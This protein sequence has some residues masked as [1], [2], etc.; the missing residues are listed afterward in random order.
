MN[1]FSNLLTKIEDK[2]AV[3]G[4]VGIGYVGKAEGE[5]IA[6]ANFNVIGFDIL[7]KSVDTI[8]N[9]KIDKF[10]ATT[11]MSKLKDCDIIFISVPTPINDEKK[12]DLTYVENSSRT[13]RDHLK[14]GQLIVLESTVAAGTTRDVLI[15]ILDEKGLKIEEEYFVGYSPE[16]V[17]IGNFEYN[18]I[19]TPKVISGYFKKSLDLVKKFYSQI[20]KKVVPTTSL[21]A[22]ELCKIME[23]TVRFININL[24]NEFAEYAA[25]KGIDIHDVINAAATKPY[26]YFPYYPSV[27]I[28]GHC[29][30]VDPY[31]LLDDGKKFSKNFEIL[32]TAMDYHEKRK[33]NIVE[34]AFELSKK[35][36]PNILVIGIAIKPGSNDARESVGI[37]LCDLI[38]QKKGLAFYHDPFVEQFNDLK[39]SDLTKD[40]LKSIDAIIIVTDHNEID[41]DLL[42]ERNIPIIDTKNTFENKKNIYRL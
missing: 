7:K 35:Q 38:K 28:S 37:K 12:P 22:A 11:N 5:F 26:G 23:N 29:I 19:T 32:Q 42:Y 31:Y 41:Y 10:T 15:P 39:S 9:L 17:D 8:N 6:K 20:V 40:F 21:E 1:Y 33:K 34:M 24:I 14:K 3:I 13:I 27:G 36:N 18:F 25:K 4:M 16:R 30:P 2:S